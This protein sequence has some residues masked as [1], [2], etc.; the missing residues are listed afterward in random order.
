M[1][2]VLLSGGSGKRLW[3]LSNEARPKQYLKLVNRE[4][5]S[6]EHCS[7]LQRVW[8]Q[9]ESAK[10][11]KNTIITTEKEQVELIKS[12]VKN[13]EIALEPMRRDTFGAVLLSCAY[14]YKY[15]KAGLDDYAAIMPV[16][17]YTEEGYFE[18]I[19][20]L[21]AVMKRTNAEVGLMGVVPTYP[22]TKY[23]YILP[24]KRME[25][26]FEVKGFSEKPD[27]EKAKE[28]F[29][30][31]A[32]W[33]CG[34]FCVRIGD[35][36]ERAEKYGVSKDYDELYLSYEKLPKISF[37]YEV[38][39]KATKLAMVT[40]QGYW[41]DL[42]T[43]D[44]MAEQISTDCIGNVVMDSSCSNTQV[45]NELTIPVV[46][47]G[48]ENLVIAA[49]QDGILVTD[50]SQAWKVKN[51]T[52]DLVSCP[53]FEERR[54]GTLE[55]LNHTK[56]DEINSLTRKI[57][58]YDGMTSSYHYHTERDEIWTILNGTGELILEGNKIPLS[59]G[60]AICIRKNQ[61]HAVKAFQ[62]FEYIEIH[63]GTSVGN[64]DIHR[65]TFQWDEIELTHI[66]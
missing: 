8:E 18:K 56:N 35:I 52:K 25:G 4:M 27:E 63:V 32:L 61:R 54:W 55:T 19:K 62:D 38:L 11:Q 24:G 14:L 37:D 6:M 23:G 20:E 36:L 26:Y 22:S 58:I 39:E 48:A 7:M 1:Y 16:D 65:I 44:A 59:P 30:Q 9:L 49:S 41:K 5:N 53:M 15:K 45:I 51:V 57:K 47:M 12:Q 33:N 50:K 31:G 42:G 29:E 10:I 43:W 34:V 28:F 60:K 2:Y 66:L 46:A 3:P 40:F 64:D 13:A 17:P 21:E